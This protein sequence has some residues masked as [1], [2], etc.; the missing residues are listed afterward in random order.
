MS[1]Y[2]L[3]A[4]VAAAWILADEPDTTAGAALDRLESGEAYVPQLWHL[5][6]RNVLLVAER[7]GRVAPGEATQHLNALAPGCRSKPIL[8]RTWKGLMGWPEFTD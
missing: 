4:S 2:V 8:R 3:D 5:E 6:I 7:R 1:A